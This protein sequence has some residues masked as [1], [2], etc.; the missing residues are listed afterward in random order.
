MAE[1]EKLP[2]DDNS[3]DFFKTLSFYDDD[4]IDLPFESFFGT[5]DIPVTELGSPVAGD[6][7]ADRVLESV[8][9]TVVEQGVLPRKVATVHPF[10]LNNSGNVPPESKVGIRLAKFAVDPATSTPSPQGPPVMARPVLKLAN[11]AVD[12]GV[13]SGPSS[14]PSS[15]GREGP[16]PP[17]L[18]QRPLFSPPVSCRSPQLPSLTRAPSPHANIAATP[19]PQS[20]AHNVA[21]FGHFERELEYRYAFRTVDYNTHNGYIIFSS[22]DNVYIKLIVHETGLSV[23]PRDPNIWQS[24]GVKFINDQHSSWCFLT[25]RTKS[26]QEGNQQMTIQAEL[27]MDLNHFSMLV[28][29]KTNFVLSQTRVNALNSE[30]LNTYRMGEISP[31]FYHV[32]KPKSYLRPNIN[33]LGNECIDPNIRAEDRQKTVQWILTELKSRTARDLPG[34]ASHIENRVYD[35]FAKQGQVLFRFVHQY[36]AEIRKEMNTFI[37]QSRKEPQIL[38]LLD[39]QTLHS[40]QKSQH[41]PVRIP[42]GVTLEPQSS[43]RVKQE[44]SAQ[45]VSTSVVSVKREGQTPT[46]QQPFQSPGASYQHY[47]MSQHQQYHQMHFQQNAQNSQ[48]ILSQM[49]RE[50]HLQLQKMQKEREM[51]DQLIQKEREMQRMEEQRRLQ[52]EREQKI[53][54]EQQRERE[55]QLLIQSQQRERERIV[56]EKMA[57]ERILQE[58]KKREQ[59]QKFL[60]LRRK[61]QE[62]QRMLMIQK[63]QEEQR[64]AMMQAQQE[65]ILR[66]QQENL[67]RQ[68]IQEENQRQAQIRQRQAQIQ[69][70][71]QQE[72]LRQQEFHHQQEQLRHQQELHHQQE[73]L[74]QQQVLQQQHELHQQQFQPGSQQHSMVSDSSASE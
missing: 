52:R 66:Q 69:L 70:R 4:P 46:G 57:Q 55:K 21:C 61:Q 30:C 23:L 1:K 2:D 74:R 6:D 19:P 59:E 53:L 37:L 51:R 20:Q 29:R 31:S 63:Q 10:S 11:F 65:Q 16:G 72:Q 64:R 44:P 17:P 28:Q 45:T 13:S 3:K 50:N 7:V 34:R 58:Q 5:E 32:S 22:L 14:G 56:R 36:Y 48:Q 24:V 39:P 60:E 12:P 15:G 38:E 43:A 41:S 18:T 40:S 47:P 9:E 8:L 62:E 42:P 73:Q 25:F 54:M 26:P 67:R 35:R 27:P 68:K 33:N 49:E 71:Q